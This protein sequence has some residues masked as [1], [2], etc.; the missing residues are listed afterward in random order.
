MDV[1][2]TEFT[3]MRTLFKLLQPLEEDITGKVCIMTRDDNSFKEDIVVV[4]L[5]ITSEFV[6][7]TA[8]TNINIHVPDIR[9]NIDGVQQLKP[10]IDRMN[11][12]YLL[13]ANLIDDAR[14]ED[15][16]LRIV[17]HHT[18]PESS[19][20]SHYVNVVVGWKIWKTNN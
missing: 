10:N 14:V 1:V 6:G 16:S 2:Y 18:L 8:T 15:V 7:Q 3:L 4:P 17:S 11:E 5:A 19:I 9:V 13:V 12:L 20:Q